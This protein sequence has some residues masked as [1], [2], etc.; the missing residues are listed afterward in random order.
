MGGREGRSGRKV[1]EKLEEGRGEV[2]GREGRSGRK[3][4]ECSKGEV[5]AG[6]RDATKNGDRE[7]VAEVGG[8]W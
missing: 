6:R 7:W 4:G 2:G 5:A 3:G 8:R 1:G